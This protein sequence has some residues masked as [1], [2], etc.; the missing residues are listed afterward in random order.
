[1]NKAFYRFALNPLTLVDI[2]QMLR[3]GEIDRALAHAKA[4][5]QKIG[6]FDCIDE[7]DGEATTGD[8]DLINEPVNCY[9]PN[10]TKL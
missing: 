8:P 7:G 1:M 10:S 4:K 6:P 3:Y 5:L 9:G 2:V